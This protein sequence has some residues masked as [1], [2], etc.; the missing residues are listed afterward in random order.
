MILEN[1]LIMAWLTNRTLVIPHELHFDH[2]H[3]KESF[4]KFIDFRYF[5][6]LCR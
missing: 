5:V 6:G 2:M 4:E 3:G 1:A